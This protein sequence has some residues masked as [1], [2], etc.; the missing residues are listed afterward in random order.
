MNI[1][2]FLTALDRVKKTGFNKWIACC[3]VHND[4]TPSLAIR[5]VEGDRL[6][7]HCF[8]CGANGIEICKSLNINPEELFPPRLENHKR[9]RVPFPA[10]QILS[11]LVHEVGI[12]TAASHAIA[13]GEKLNANDVRRIETARE[14]LTEGLNYAKT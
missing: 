7:F 9:E 11:A 10:E 1:D 5:L 8:G 14:R 3:P 2:I 6:L 13:N 12:V 4:K